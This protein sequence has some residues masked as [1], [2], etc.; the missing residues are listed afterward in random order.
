MWDF[1]VAGSIPAAAVSDT[2]TLDASLYLDYGA[3][4]HAGVYRWILSDDGSYYT[5]VSVDKNGTPVTAQESAVNVGANNEERRH[6]QKEI[7]GNSPNEADRPSFSQGTPYHMRSGMMGAAGG[8]IYQGVYMN[9]NITNVSNQTMLIYVPAAYLTTD[10]SGN[11]TGINHE[12]VIGQY[13][14]DTTPI[15][16]LNE[17]GGWRSSSPRSVDSS[18][19]AEGFVYVTAGARSRDAVDENGLHTG[20]APTPVVDLK[21]GVIALRA[22]NEVIPGDKNRI[23]SIGTSGGGQMSSILGASGNMPEYYPY[24]YEAGALGVSRNSDGTYTSHYPDNIFAAQAYCPIADIEDADLAY[25]WWWVDLADHG[26]YRGSFTDFDRRLQE[27]EAEAFITYLNSLNL[28]DDHGNSL[29]LTG[30][31]SGSYYDAILANISSALNTTA[32][33]SE[34]DPAADYADADWLTKKEDGTW[35]VTDLAGFMMG[36]GL[37]SR[38]NKAIPGFDPLD[39]SAEND[40]FGSAEQNAVHFSRSVAQILSDHYDELSVLEGFDAEQVQNYISEALT[41]KNADTVAEQAN[42]LNATEIMFG[43]DGH[44]AVSPAEYWRI[45]SGTADQHTSFSIGFNIGLAALS[46]GKNVDYSLV[47]NMGHGSNEGT[48]TGT[49]INWINTICAR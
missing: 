6:E 8:T 27:L 39:K 46:M 44:H 12:A 32:A 35:Q 28:K 15:V 26:G 29:T 31:R 20:K 9:A 4:I 2:D 49:F 18:Y 22:N 25:A 1:P 48:Y 21:S 43:T 17:C 19:I 11:V 16:Y 14:A 23:I 47:W 41:G 34:T 30:I 7:P 10:A 45:R 13:T 24:L 42:L 33:S 38:R 5:L 36:T 37:V 3:G 40:A